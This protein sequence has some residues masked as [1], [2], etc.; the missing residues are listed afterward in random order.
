MAYRWSVSFG[1]VLV[2]ALSTAC[3]N[4]VPRVLSDGGVTSDGGVASDGQAAEPDA[5]PATDGP[6]GPDDSTA[7]VG[8]HCSSQEPCPGSLFCDV[9]PSASGRGCGQSNVPR[10]C[11]AR[12]ATCPAGGA[13]VCGCDGVTY[14]SD[15]LRQKAGVPVASPG[16]CQGWE[17]GPIG[18][19]TMTCGPSQVCVQPGGQCG[20][21]PPCTPAPDGGACPAGLVACIDLTTQRPGCTYN[22]A[23]QPP[24]CLDVPAICHGLPDC[25]CL[26][27]DHCYCAWIKLGRMVMCFG[28]A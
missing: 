17:K 11:M 18:C 14:P 10:T 25:D 7:A 4:S 6:S 8:S 3:T 22:C 19:G 15:C 20:L 1:L 26:R 16:A 13:A 24:Y 23:P 28:A 27:P 5:G 21:P 9:S 12:P 2:A